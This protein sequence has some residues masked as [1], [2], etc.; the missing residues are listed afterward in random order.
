MIEKRMI[1]HGDWKHPSQITVVR[2]INASEL[3]SCI[4]GKRRSN[5][6]S[7]FLIRAHRKS[8]ESYNGFPCRGA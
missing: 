8:V 1:S 5:D 2:K 3:F 6:A 7:T 4:S